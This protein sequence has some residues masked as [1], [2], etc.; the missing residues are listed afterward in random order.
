[1][2]SGCQG[3]SDL[4]GQKSLRRYYTQFSLVARKRLGLACVGLR[5]SCSLKFPS[6]K[7]FRGYQVSV[8]HRL[9]RLAAFWSETPSHQMKILILTPQSARADLLVVCNTFWDWKQLA[10]PSLCTNRLPPRYPPIRIA[11]CLTPLFRLGILR[12][13]L[14]VV[15]L[16]HSLRSFTG[17]KSWLNSWKL[18]LLDCINFIPECYWF[19]NLL[20]IASPRPI[21]KYSR[22]R[23]LSFVTNESIYTK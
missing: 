13:F 14:K 20:K 12:K 19:K 15:K 22:S 7:N 11:P 9:H 5:E 23:M 16:K 18:V 21:S 6:F 8:S 1:M 10:A 4:R 3:R 2:Y 17:P